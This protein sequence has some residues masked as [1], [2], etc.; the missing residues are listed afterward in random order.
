MEIYNSEEEQVEA[1]KRWWQANGTSVIGGVIV[2][3]AIIGGWNFW[4]SYQRDQAEQAST[5]YQQLVKAVSENQLE[6]AD[7]ISEQISSQ[8][9]STAYASYAALIQAKVKVDQGDLAAARQLLEKI[10]AS[11]D[12]AL[13]HVANIRLLRL[14]LAAGEFEQGLQL[15]AEVDQASAQNFSASYE[16]IKGDFYVSLDRQGEARTAYQ[17]AQRN[18]Q[19]SPLLQFKLDD[20]A[21]PELIESTQ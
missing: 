4:Q 9:G 5:L 6:S 17:N 21:A 7:K 2:G 3:V 1:L 8:L 11:S 12:T 19:G 16:E 13:Q 15:I 10:A 18:G 14:M 20:L